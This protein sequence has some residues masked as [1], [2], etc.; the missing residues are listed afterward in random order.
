LQAAV[1]N[2]GGLLRQMGR[3]EEEIQATLRR[4]APEMF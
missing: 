3:S 2:Y 4:I 1:N